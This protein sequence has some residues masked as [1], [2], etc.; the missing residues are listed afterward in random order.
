MKVESIE[1]KVK[2]YL[3]KIKK[4]KVEHSN[5]YKGINNNISNML[6]GDPQGSP[7]ESFFCFFGELRRRIFYG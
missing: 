4:G 3:E 6:L 1:D 2:A 7:D 5:V